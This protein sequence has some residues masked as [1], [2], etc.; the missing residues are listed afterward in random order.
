MKRGSWLGAAALAALLL[1]RPGAA[2]AGAAR[3]M[4]QWAES[5]APAL[6]PFLAL[7]PLLTCDEAA[8]AYERLLGRPLRALLDLP[9]PAAS[10]MVVGMVAG[11]PAGAMAARR[12]AARGGMDRGQLKRLALS[13]TGFSPAFLIGGVGA[14]LM[15]DAAL[16]RRLFLVQLATQLVLSLAL[17]RA[18]RNETGP[19]EPL[20][21]GGEAQPVRAAVLAVLG[22]CGY[23]AL[24]QS[25]AGALSAF[26]GPGT[27]GVLLCAM[28]AP[29][30]ARVIAGL[31]EVFNGLK[32]PLLAAVCGFGG[33]CVALQNL[34]A[35]K[36]CGIRASE[37]LAARALAAGIGAGCMA[38]PTQLHVDGGA[39]LARL[40]ARP[41]E[42]AALG[43]SLLAIPV[44]LRWRKSIS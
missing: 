10:A 3:A 25:A 13:I 43:A 16:G 30:G 23:M 8:R 35:L 5:V 6:F 7:M 12:V 4:A 9:G 20:P 17:R 39:L 21:D 33:G 42:T 38:L 28:D 2:M 37:Y 44:L 18:F 1:L 36:G 24:F 34:A 15:G 29:S 32:P 22:V 26:V 31:P 19:V 14:G 41:L 27:A 11:A 40:A